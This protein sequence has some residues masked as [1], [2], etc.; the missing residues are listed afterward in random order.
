MGLLDGMDRQ[1]EYKV[2]LKIEEQRI[3]IEGGMLYKAVQDM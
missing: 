3:D 2:F 1:P